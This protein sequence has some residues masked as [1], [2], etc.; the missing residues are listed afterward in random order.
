MSSSSPKPL[1]RLR[2]KS[3]TESWKQERRDY[4]QRGWGATRPE[5]QSTSPFQKKF[6]FQFSFLAITPPPFNKSQPP[7]WIVIYPPTLLLLPAVWVPQAKAART[8]DSTASW[9]S[10]TQTW[11]ETK[12][13]V[14]QDILYSNLHEAKPRL[15]TFL[16]RNSLWNTNQ[17]RLPVAAKTTMLCTIIPR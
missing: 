7:Q 3:A 12:I 9:T 1:S 13:I 8:T 2:G 15:T 5:E 11:N 10:N 4:F 6:Y 17:M 16:K 14:W